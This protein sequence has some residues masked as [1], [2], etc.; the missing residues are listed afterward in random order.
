MTSAL[1]RAQQKE[2]GF[3][4]F[5]IPLPEGEGG[6]V[7]IPLPAG[8]GGAR[9]VAVGGRG[10]TRTAALPALRRAAYPLSPALSPWERESHGCS[11]SHG[12]RVAA[13]RSGE[14]F[15]LVR[16]GPVLFS[17]PGKGAILTSHGE[18]IAGLTRSLKDGFAAAERPPGSL[19]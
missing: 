6:R 10:I 4:A 13:K 17:P 3:P 19:D 5:P 14:G 2:S 1:G 9:R 12:E 15:H 16:T 18:T 7:V 11:L 8:E